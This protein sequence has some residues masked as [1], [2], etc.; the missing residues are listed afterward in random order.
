MRTQLTLLQRGVIQRLRARNYASLADCC[1][2]A[3]AHGERCNLRPIIAEHEAEL[4]ADFEKAQ[5]QATL[6]Y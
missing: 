1:A 2:D 4:R 3:W 5:L 6:E